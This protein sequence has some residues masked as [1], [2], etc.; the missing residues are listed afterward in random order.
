MELRDKHLALLVA[1]N[2]KADD[3]VDALLGK[4]NR[5]KITESPEARQALTDIIP[6]LL[7][8]VKTNS[9]QFQPKE[10]MSSADIILQ[11]A[12][13]LACQKPLLEAL[14]NTTNL[15][16]SEAPTGTQT[17][18]LRQLTATFKA[19]LEKNEAFGLLFDELGTGTRIYRPIENI[20]LGANRN[21]IAEYLDNTTHD[22]EFKLIQSFAELHFPEALTD[23]VLLNLIRQPERAN[24]LLSLMEADALKLTDGDSRKKAVATLQA[25]N[26]HIAKI[27]ELPTNTA[28]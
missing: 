13:E 22:F 1:N 9:G 18:A 10:D 7:E 26:E 8:E 23:P 14:G 6:S 21:A 25:L 11:R 17:D 16:P 24:T 5:K 15:I 27:A 3:V 19:G 28:T 2:P 20:W 12:L 4:L